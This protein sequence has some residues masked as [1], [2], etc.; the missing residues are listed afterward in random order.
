MWMFELQKPR[1]PDK[2]GKSMS[3]IN[4]WKPC[5]SLI[6]RDKVTVGVICYYG[7]TSEKI[8]TSLWVTPIIHLNKVTILS[9]W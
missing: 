2:L 8:T 3:S 6:G 4:K 9:D 5:K 7:S 1:N